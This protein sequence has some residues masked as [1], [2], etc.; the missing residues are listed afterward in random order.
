MSK[1]SELLQRPLQKSGPG[2]VGSAF[3]GRSRN[4]TLIVH[5]EGGVLVE[6][7]EATGGHGLPDGV[8]PCV[9]GVGKLPCLLPDV[10]GVEPG[11][12][13]PVFGL[14]VEPD[15]VSGRVTQGVLL[16]VAF[17]SVVDGC[18]LLPGVVVFGEVELGAVV[19]VGG[20]VVGVAGLA[21]G[22]AVLPGGVAVPGVWVCP[23][24]PGAPAGGVPLEGVFCATTHIVQKSS[25][26]RKEP[27]RTDI[28][29][30]LRVDFLMIPSA[31]Q[32]AR[33]QESSLD[34]LST[35]RRPKPIGEML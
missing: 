23:A 33:A 11:L 1:P 24:A 19:V 31:C 8:V 18:V 35:S 28:C 20:G 15:A 13:D 26:E 10:D 3:K 2:R 16:G 30:N 21:G 6:S 29:R 7:G 5:F 17:G 32:L 27:F 34:S 4:S 9:P 14:G 12:E 22:V 25:R